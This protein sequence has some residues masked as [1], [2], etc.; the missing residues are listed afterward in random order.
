MQKLVGQL[1]ALNDFDVMVT[2]GLYNHTSGEGEIG[3]N[4]MA[5]KHKL[6]M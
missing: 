5:C 3:Q 4:R 2:D 6:D 1:A